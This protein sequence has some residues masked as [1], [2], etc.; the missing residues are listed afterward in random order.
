MASFLFSLEFVGRVRIIFRFLCFLS[1]SISLW[2]C[3]R[4]KNVCEC[5]WFR[6][7]WCRDRFWKMEKNRENAQNQ[8]IVFWVILVRRTSKESSVVLC[9][10]DAV[11]IIH[12]FIH[13]SLNAAWLLSVRNNTTQYTKKRFDFHAFKG[14]AQIYRICVMVLRKTN[15]SLLRYSVISL[16][17]IPLYFYYNTC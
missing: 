10:L 11:H 9:I 3:G 13:A 12:S 17:S 16:Y 2:I 8:L 14:L 5:W 7:H 15:S 4:A 6:R 1:R